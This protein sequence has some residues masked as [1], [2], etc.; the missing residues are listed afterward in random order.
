MK[1]E[2]DRANIMAS[3]H[4]ATGSHSFLIHTHFL[5]YIF[6]K[7]RFGEKNAIEWN[8]KMSN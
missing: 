1:Y 6:M 7:E 4:R 2:S 5:A 3:Y 8:M